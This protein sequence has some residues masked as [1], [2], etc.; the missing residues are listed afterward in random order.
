MA[1]SSLLPENG[2]KFCASEIPLTIVLGLSSTGCGGIFQA[3]SGEIHS[4]NYPSPYRSNTDCTW[5]IQVEKHHRVLLNF[6]DFDLEPQDSCI[7]VS[8]TNLKHCLWSKLCQNIA[9]SKQSMF[10]GCVGYGC[11]QCQITGNSTISNLKYKHIYFLPK[12]KPGSLF[13][14]PVSALPFLVNWLFILCLLLLGPKVAAAVPNTLSSNLKKK[15]RNSVSCF[16][17][18]FFFFQSIKQNFYRSLFIDNRPELA[19]RKIRK[20]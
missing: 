14:N 18:V 15:R 2:V 4:P 3:P 13:N 10:S 12:H 20:V 17:L 8:D 9:M 11:F 5:V 19:A 6:T 16:P 7:L 1:C